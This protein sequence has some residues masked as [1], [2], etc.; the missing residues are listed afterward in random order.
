MIILGSAILI[1]P[2]VLPERTET[3]RLVIPENSKEMLPQ[4]GMVVDVGP[5]CIL[6]KK[7]DHVNFPRK[8]ASVIVIEGVDHFFVTEHKLFYIK[9]R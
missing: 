7:G 1:K 4:W 3:G 6:V 9:E 8:S 5:L 2:N